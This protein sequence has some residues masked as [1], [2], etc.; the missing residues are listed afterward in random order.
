MKKRYSDYIRKNKIDFVFRP[1][2]R[3]IS[4][5]VC[6]AIYVALIM[7]LGAFY[8]DNIVM[9]ICL[10]VTY[11]VLV[12]FRIKKHAKILHRT[13][14]Q[15]ALFANS[16]KKNTEF[17]LIID[18]GGDIIYSDERA[19]LTFDNVSDFLKECNHQES[20]LF[21]EALQD[22]AHY[23]I[24][25]KSATFFP[26]HPDLSLELF[27]LN[28]PD[29]YFLLKA[30]RVTKEVIYSEVMAEHAVGN[31][32]LN[33]HGLLTEANK[34]FLKLI[35]ADDISSPIYLPQLLTP[36]K[37]VQLI[38]LLK[39]TVNV[40]VTARSLIDVNGDQCIYGLVT[41]KTFE[42]SEFLDA[43]IPIAQF[44]KD[45]K[46][47]K[48]N[49]AFSDLTYVNCLYFSDITQGDIDFKLYF[50]NIQD[51][52][53]VSSV[54]LVDGRE[55]EI[56]LKKCLDNMIVYFFDITKYKKI[57]DQLLHSQK[58]HSI[59]ELAGGIAHDFNNILTAIIGF[60]DLALNR[61]S[62]QDQTFIDIM[63]IKQ[64]AERATNLVSKLLAFS[65][66][67]TLQLEV[68]NIVPMLQGISSLIQRLIGENIKLLIH[69]DN[70]IGNVKADK[71]QLEQVVMNLAI[72][73]RD[74]LNDIGTFKIEASEVSIK[75]TNVKGMLPANSEDLIIPGEYVA[76]QFS[77]NGSGIPEDIITK[78]FDPFFSTKKEGEGTGLGLSTV[79]GI[80]RQSGGYTYISSTI[81][82]G[83]SIKIF[84]P[85]VYE[86]ITNNVVD[87]SY[88]LKLHDKEK[89]KKNILLVED[90]EAVA[91]FI[92]Q[93]LQ[94]E[95]YNLLG[96][97]SS[98]DAIEVFR[99]NTVDII[100]TD[101][102]MPEMSGEE[103][104]NCIR[105]INPD[106]EIIFISGYSEQKLENINYKY[107]FLQK[108]FSLDQL[109][110]KI[111][112]C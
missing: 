64:N 83:T 60:C 51:N 93:A 18:K 70:N 86:N 110:A 37:E 44:D 31:Y 35:E 94:N 92:T 5:I 102:I 11:S 40:Y 9:A 15:N 6:N 36:D 34:S 100:I 43:P 14:F 22:K 21:L 26:D 99:N 73:A 67:Q 103:M 41:P 90:E 101:V 12:T 112:D 108:P 58:V 23:R 62:F 61:Y 48:R 33:S 75:D 47:L 52:F 91:M 96:S 111:Q 13:E 20:N 45:G 72:N 105:E 2:G 79:N 59:G 30:V 57:E 88:E 76:L 63:Q 39:N 27:S 42:T 85:K 19:N 46:V 89:L 53:L 97:E 77:D 17:F 4:L 32:I 16:L 8:P 81:G 106:V 78:V 28:R 10:A 84:L 74:A 107:H 71:G 55:F 25:I 80:I 7:F 69:Y 65:R 50:S 56:F 109:I 1:H 66:R 82:H 3:V 49:Q 38:T 98:V 68:L 24:K 95:G 104:I 87:V 29:G 54:K